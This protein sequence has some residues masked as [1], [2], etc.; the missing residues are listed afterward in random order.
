MGRRED[1]IRD[2]IQNMEGNEFERFAFRILY[3]ELYPGLNP[4]SRSYDFGEDA[5]TEWTTLFLN[6]NQWVSVCASKTTEIT[7]LRADCQRAKDNGKTIDIVIF[8]TAHEVRGD[9]EKEWREQILTDFGWKLEIRSLDY[10][11]PTAADRHAS[12]VSDYLQIPPPGGDFLHNIEAEFEHLTKQTLDATTVS[13]DGLSEPLER[14]EVFT[15]EDQL[16][17]G[18]PVLLRGEAGTGKSGIGAMLARAA[19]ANGRG[20]IL[21]D[22]RRATHVISENDLRK[23]FNLNGAVE[24]AIAR[25]A[26]KRGCRVIIDQF[27]NA[28]GRP[29]ADHL[30]NLANACS[31]IENTE[32]IVISRKIEQHEEDTLES[33]VGF[34]ELLSHPLT[35]V[36]VASVLKRLG[37]SDVSPALVTLCCNL[38]NLSLVATLKKKQPAYDFSTILN[39]IDLW[40]G[41]IGALVKRERIDTQPN[42]G[43][44]VI[45]EAEVL[46][47]EGLKR[48]DRSVRLDNSRPLVHQRLVSWQILI[49]E[50]GDI[51]HFRHGRLQDFLVARW[52]T[53]QGVLPSEILREFDKHRTLGVFA[54]MDKLYAR[55]PDS[56]RRGKFLKELFALNDV[57]FYAQAAVLQHYFNLREPDAD[58]V[59]L[60]ILLEVLRTDKGLRSY[61]FRCRPSPQWAPVLWNEGF[62]D[63]PPP[64]QPFGH[65]HLLAQWDAQDYLFSV[66]KDIP[67]LLIEH[68]KCLRGDS[69]YAERTVRALC[70]I[71]LEEA[72]RA[73]PRVLE[74]MADYHIGQTVASAVVEFIKQ[75]VV[76]RR[77]GAA[78]DLFRGL[79]MPHPSLHA[80]EILGHVFSGEA[81]A[82]FSSSGGFAHQELPDLVRQIAGEERE[83][84]V[85][86]L[87]EHLLEAIQIETRTRRL[88]HEYVW[89]GWNNPLAET[90]G[91]G[92]D[93]YKSILLRLLGKTL[94]EWIERDANAVEPLIEK[95]LGES[96]SPLESRSILRRLAVHLLQKYT[97][98]YQSLVRQELLD[99]ESLNTLDAKDEFLLL[100]RN[101]HKYLNLQE[102]DVLI[103]RISRG[104][105]PGV[106]GQLGNESEQGEVAEH[107]LYLRHFEK[108]WIRDYLAMLR[109]C[110]PEE[111]KR[112]LTELIQEVGEPA[113]PDSPRV[114]YQSDYVSEVSPLTKE[115]LAS[116]SPDALV[117]FVRNW[118]PDLDEHERPRT[119]YE[120]FA[121]LVAEEM[122]L[123]PVKYY[124]AINSVATVRHQFAASLI[125]RLTNTERYPLAWEGRIAL[126]ENLL[127]DEVIRTDM[128]DT[129]NDGW[130][131][132][133]L[134]VVRL[135]ATW[136]DKRLIPKPK[137]YLPP[138]Y[139]PRVRDLLLLL[140]DDPDPERSGDE[141]L[142]DERYERNVSLIA[143]GH[144]RSSALSTLI[145]YSA[146]RVKLGH[147]LSKHDAPAVVNASSHIESV[148]REVLTRKLNRQSD[149][150]CAVHSIYGEH[151]SALR[152]LDS[153]WVDSQLERIFPETS[154]EHLRWCYVAAWDSY[155]KDNHDVD[156]DL[157]EKMREMYARAIENLRTGW[158]TKT[159]PQPPRDLAYHLLS[160]YLHADYDLRSEDGQQSLIADFFRKLPPLARGDGAWVLWDICNNNR[161]KLNVYWKRALTLWQWRVAEAS[162]ANHS[163][164]F[165]DEMNWFTLLLRLA[166]EC[167]ETISSIWPLLE[168]TL[169]HVA[170][171]EPRS[172][173]WDSVEKYLAKEVEHDALR[174]IKLYYM[175]LAERKGSLEMYYP[176]EEGHKI[177]RTALSCQDA[178]YEAVEM[179][180]FLARYGNY[181]FQDYID[182]TLP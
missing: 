88:S 113:T 155:L 154:D 148:V 26:R 15:I 146:Y 80:Q 132:V 32:I 23:C 19:Q 123:N 52:A 2:A 46:A 144:V 160:D 114:L 128:S 68:I 64:P 65:H 176:R 177:V 137:E 156:L 22:S 127:A 119:A 51:H 112:L 99:P 126:C 37:V 158:V 56:A 91:F 73:V 129:I 116:M 35:E 98:S 30:T 82:L 78:F 62:F 43:E 9:K 60:P 7:K 153:K 94:E 20:V 44:Q 93:E 145:I 152:W 170:R 77:N 172:T 173:G 166:A 182:V 97:S 10:F 75:L 49:L 40:E 3:E 89:S 167:A 110:L 12:L 139:L 74:W 76:E 140:C 164:D 50:E 121:D 124:D 39:E 150:S 84:M 122:L 87:E 141:E 59:A 109:D 55:R 17:A 86:I 163:A 180:N 53:K 133:R 179:I 130:R 101:G 107:D 143:H 63:E 90:R 115:R 1:S 13:I 174:A 21:L 175:M 125:I 106:K 103:T 169:P 83:Q 25:V 36:R 42:F 54:W 142:K 171:A 134:S 66:A 45:V 92:R 4:T 81:V 24:D 6:G 38:L 149:P 108:R 8:A 67:S 47:K 117:D 104:L 111:P 100:L 96:R 181:C 28:V 72:E 135:I 178:E 71:S 165:D 120:S 29:V 105:P 57:P 61:F 159:S 11:A 147:H 5:R 95:Y 136:M 138:G 102:Q 161:D 157:F 18:K 69:G 58:S 70:L 162:G 118:Q 131:G 151:L 14:D 34:F 16:K 168:G 85:A 31:R 33:F 41:F 27:D 79:T 48:D